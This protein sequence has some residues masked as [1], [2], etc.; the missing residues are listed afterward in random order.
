MTSVNILSLSGSLRHASTNTALLGAAKLLA[1][2][3]TI[4]TSWSKFAELPHFNPD[5]EVTSVE[6]VQEFQNVVRSCDAVL[7]ACPE[8]ARGIPGAFKNGLDWLVGSE[9]LVN[10]HV[11]LWNASPRASAAQDALRL[12][13][14]TM[15]GHIV[16]DGC[17]AVPLINQ[18]VTAKSL[19]LD[20]SIAPRIIAAIAA[21]ANHVAYKR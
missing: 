20:P 19:S 17:L 13:I 18:Q 14:E 12:V 1:P 8:Y 6:S 7:I 10:K 9:G 3:N 21:L 2:P 15:S 16:E 4:I 11:A 5:M